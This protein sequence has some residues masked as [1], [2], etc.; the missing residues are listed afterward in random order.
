V[1]HTPFHH[2]NPFLLRGLIEQDKLKSK[3]IGA[4]KRPNAASASGGTKVVVSPHDKHKQLK[5]H[6]SSGGV[7][8]THH[9]PSSKPKPNEQHVS[10]QDGKK[11]TKVGGGEAMFV[12]TPP[13]DYANRPPSP[14]NDDNTI[15]PPWKSANVVKTI[16]NREVVRL[17][18]K[19]TK[20]FAYFV[21]IYKDSNDE[22][23]VRA[24]MPTWANNPNYTLHATTTKPDEQH[25]KA[26]FDIFDNNN[27]DSSSPLPTPKD[28]KRKQPDGD[29]K[30]PS[31]R[32]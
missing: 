31:T 10:I 22:E 13:E 17:N 19:F 16:F 20:K 4:K 27:D 26:V 1:P 23:P 3:Q 5:H 7:D 30:D 32:F 25:H 12:L 24:N 14:T 9:H 8:S 29:A 28:E 11:P 15:P 6:G 18:F 2:Q 21:K